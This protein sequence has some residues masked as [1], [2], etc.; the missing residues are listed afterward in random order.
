MPLRN[1]ERFT[2]KKKIKEKLWKMHC[3]SHVDIF[4]RLSEEDILQ[5]KFGLFLLH[6]HLQGWVMERGPKRP[7]D[8]SSFENAGV[9]PDIVLVLQIDPQ[10]VFRR[11]ENRRIDPL[12]KKI[13]DISDPHSID[14][15]ILS[16]LVRRKDDN[17]EYFSSR[18]KMFQKEGLGVVSLYQ[19]KD[20]D[21]VY[22]LDAQQTP[23]NLL[24]EALIVLKSKSYRIP[25]N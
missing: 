5:V 9:M 17:I 6:P 15:I 3:M 22:F 23:E 11:M 21:M 4:S 14:P 20:K 7:E 19:K 1:G 16:R 25:S 24:Q 13:Y 12:T 18:Q 10:E 8:F 2:R